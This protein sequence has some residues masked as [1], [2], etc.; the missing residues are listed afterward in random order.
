MSKFWLNVSNCINHIKHLTHCIYY[1]I[2][3]RKWKNP[4]KSKRVTQLK[5]DIIDDI[6]GDEDANAFPSLVILTPTNDAALQLNDKI[7]D[8]LAGE[9]I[10]FVCID[11]VVSDEQ[12]DN[13]NRDNLMLIYLPLVIRVVSFT[14]LI[15]S[16]FPNNS[17]SFLIRDH[18]TFFNLSLNKPSTQPTPSCLINSSASSCSTSLDINSRAFGK[19]SR[20]NSEKVFF[21]F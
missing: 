10:T 11:S 17:S 20:P 14:V 5:D 12:E 6:F 8:K 15:K 1:C 13:I 16:A 9:A 21:S 18:G 19:Q 3:S 2:V 7:L 4:I